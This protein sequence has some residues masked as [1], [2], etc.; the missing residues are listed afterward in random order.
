MIVLICLVAIL[1][2]I[3]ICVFVS[4]RQKR[5]IDLEMAREIVRRKNLDVDDIE[6]EDMDMKGDGKYKTTDDGPV[7]HIDGDGPFK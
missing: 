2:P 6:V 3:C 1:I 5:V 4:L 7:K